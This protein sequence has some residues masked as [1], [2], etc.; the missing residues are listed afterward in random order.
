MGNLLDRSGTR[1]LGRVRFSEEFFRRS[2]FSTVRYYSLQSFIILVLIV[3]VFPLPRIAGIGETITN[4][5]ID[6]GAHVYAVGRDPKK[7]PPATANLT[8]VC[9]DVGEW[10]AY[11]T[12]KALGPVHGLVNNAGVAYIESFLDMTQEG[13][14]K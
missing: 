6:L 4:R 9:A 7:L 12:I 1:S 8:P 3:F 14:D 11:E 5:L 13:W 2:D 10:N